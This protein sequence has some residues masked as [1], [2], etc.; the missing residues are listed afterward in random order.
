[1][2]EVTGRG[3]ILNSGSNPFTGETYN[4]F[5]IDQSYKFTY[6]GQANGHRQCYPGSF[7][8][9]TEWS[10]LDFAGRVIV[11]IAAGDSTGFNINVRYEVFGNHDDRPNRLGETAMRKLASNVKD[12]VASY[13]EKYGVKNTIVL[14]ET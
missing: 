5:W 12:I 11:D 4:N 14:R 1:M 9:G 13:C 6:H 8:C 2:D 10:D 3:V 7:E